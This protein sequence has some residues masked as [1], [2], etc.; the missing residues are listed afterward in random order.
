MRSAL[1]VPANRP[2]RFSK[3]LASGTD[4]VIIDLEDT[5]APDAKR[6]ARDNISNFVDSNP[7]AKFWVR[8]N[9]GTTDWFDDDLSLCRSTSAV[10]GIVL[11]KANKAQ[12]VYIVSGAGKPLMPVIEAASGLHELSQIAQASG[13]TRLSFGILDLMVELGTR[14]HTDA[15]MSI[16]NQ[17]RFLILMASRIHGLARPMDCVYADFS[18]LQGFEQ[19]SIFA[20]DMGFG[21]VLCIHPSQIAVAHEVFQA[22]PEELEWAKRVVEYADKTGEYT[23]R[24]DGR[25]VDLPLIDRARRILERFE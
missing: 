8:I 14:P 18:D 6:K 5:I 3:A 15:A 16:Q 20:R 13:V 22:L 19:A 23:F 11:P 9:D 25:M 4:A 24:M 7:D 1:F 10:S 12:H 17:I 21:G 2:D